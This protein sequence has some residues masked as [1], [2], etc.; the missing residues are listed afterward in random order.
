MAFPAF[1]QEKKDPETPRTLGP[2]GRSPSAPVRRGIMIPLMPATP[3]FHQS[4][5][6]TV[7]RFQIAR[8][9]GISL[10]ATPLRWPSRGRELSRSRGL[11]LF[12]LSLAVIL[13]GRR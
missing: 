2:E 5:I 6:R 8:I 9:S 3:Y 12:L 7:S 1:P 13:V 11:R 10:P 4:P